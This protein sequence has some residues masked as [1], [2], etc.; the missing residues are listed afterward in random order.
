[1]SRTVFQEFVRDLQRAVRYHP[2]QT[3]RRTYGEADDIRQECRACREEKDRFNTDVIW[4]SS[5]SL[6]IGWEFSNRLHRLSDFR[7]K[8]RKDA[9]VIKGS[10][11]NRGQRKFWPR[12]HQEYESVSGVQIP[13]S[14][15][16]WLKTQLLHRLDLKG[17]VRRICKVK[18]RNGC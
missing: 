16:I 8:L 12:R 11:P 6:K 13:S 4:I 17:W 5:D 3:E 10:I 15:G 18:S 9:V 1:M 14:T 7:D 2:V